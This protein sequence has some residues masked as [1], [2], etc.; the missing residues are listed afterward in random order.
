MQSL[1]QVWNSL[2]AACRLALGLSLFALVAAAQ[3][4]ESRGESWN[5]QITD[6]QGSVIAG[7]EI[8]LLAADGKERNATSD[9]NGIFT[10]KNVSAGRYIVVIT[11]PNFQPFR[12]TEVLVASNSDPFKATLLVAPLSEE[13]QIVAEASGASVEPEQN[14]SA[15]ILEGEALQDLLPD[16]EEDLREFLQQ[17]AGPAAGG[18][19]GGAQIRVNGFRGGRLPP[20]EAIASVRVNS[21][22][23]SA[24]YAQSGAARVEIITKPGNDQWHGS[25]SWTA[26]NSALDARNAFAPVKPEVAQNRYSFNLSGP[27]IRKRLSFFAS[28]DYRKLTGSSTV[29]ATTLDGPFSA[30]V[31]APNSNRGLDLRVDYLLSKRNTLS[32]NYTYGQSRIANREFAVRFDSSRGIGGFTLPERGSESFNRDH[33]LRI[34]ETFIVNARLLLETRVQL[35]QGRNRAAANTN[36]AA[37]NVSGAFLGGGATCCPS[38]NT[39]SGGEWQQYLTWT[40]KKHTLRGGWQQE[41]DRVNDFSATNF[42]GT[43]TFA[44][45]E[46]YRNALAGQG[47]A[48]QFSLNRG[49]PQLNYSMWRS[50]WFINDDWRLNNR[51]TLSLGLRHEFQTQL[52]DANNFAPRIGIALA[53]SKGRKT[54]IRFGG[55]VFYNRLLGNLYENTLRYNGVRQQSIV[56]ANA[57]FPDPFAGNPTVQTRNTIRRTLDETLHAPQTISFSSSLERQLPFGLTTSTTY[58][59]SRGLHQFRTRNLNA[60]LN[61]EFPLGT[62]TG[63]L[64]QIES[65]ASSRHHS[66]L[67]RME[68][69]F[70]RAMMVI[71]NYTLAFTRSD[72]DSPN[73]L[74]ANSYDVRNEWTRALTDRRHSLFVTGRVRLPWDL[75]VAPTITASSGLPFNITSGFDENGDTSFTDRPAGL[76]RNS[77]LPANLY[78]Q[79]PNANRCVQNCQSGGSAVTLLQYLQRNHPDGVRAEGPGSFNASARLTKSFSFGKRTVT[80]ADR[81]TQR[82]DKGR[83]ANPRAVNK[84]DKVAAKTTTGADRE[85]GRFNLQFSVQISNLLNRVNF[86][87]FGG[88]LGS[89]YFGLPNSA[90]GA[91]SFE[92]STRFSF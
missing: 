18:G 16:N 13:Q 22:P 37:I 80:A 75:I 39:N 72:S 28:S 21:N 82:N 17:L 20:K 38:R 57:Q 87:Q 45:L 47:R 67:T 33:T 92:L 27:L 29:V 55:G 2:T 24:E 25:S 56:I 50:A 34:A 90:G 7:A 85:T 6:E 68:R 76:R 58:T 79:I 86:G 35:E 42:N 32:V 1:P 73:A 3:S 64:Y 84:A 30:N 49:N 23:F 14:L 91:R 9:T 65:S 11:A 77:D 46:Q 26:R 88:V 70:G 60:P 5:G 31:P 81:A 43:F 4:I 62:A 44:S 61:G 59:F 52:G 53:P 10:F 48:Q 36:G 78:V 71:A 63:A 83:A 41:Y 40:R 54:V 74:P 51:F 89:P 19:Q 69:R 15:T 66:M 12:Q 8:V